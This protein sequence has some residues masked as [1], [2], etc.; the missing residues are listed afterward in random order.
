[1]RAFRLAIVAAYMLSFAVV[2][3]AQDSL[4]QF[5][6]Y[7]IGE[8]DTLDSVMTKFPEAKER[9]IIGKSQELLA[10][11]LPSAMN[12]DAEALNKAEQVFK[13][14][15][16]DIKKY[17][18]FAQKETDYDIIPVD[19]LYCDF[20]SAT[21]FKYVMF[22]FSSFDKKLLL[23]EVSVTDYATVRK[24]LIEQYGNSPNDVWTR[25]GQCLFFSQGGDGRPLIFAYLKNS[26]NFLATLRAKIEESHKDDVDLKKAF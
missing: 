11:P 19:S 5:T 25:A 1:M 12:V 13:S 22:R 9:C 17:I 6:Y 16:S 4:K 21:T 23:T 26:E 2:A 24:R 10:D 20:P 3:H 8:N 15:N 14:I 7:D 18:A